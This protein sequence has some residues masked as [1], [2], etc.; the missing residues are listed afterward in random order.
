MRTPCIRRVWDWDGLRGNFNMGLD[1][2][3]ASV[4]PLPCFAWA[5]ACHRPRLQ[6]LWPVWAYELKDLGPWS[7]HDGT[8]QLELPLQDTRRSWD[9]TCV[10]H[11]SLEWDETD[12]SQA[13]VPRPQM[14]TQLAVWTCAKTK[15][16]TNHCHKGNS[17][18]GHR[19]HS[20]AQIHVFSPWAA[21]LLF[22]KGFLRNLTEV[23]FQSRH[24]AWI[25]NVNVF[26]N[27]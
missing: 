16:V 9:H 13:H 12:L 11:Y 7:I 22:Y 6:R 26:L 5:C 10:S 14:S 19:W 17:C 23:N 18:H 27:A 21:I 8:I 2:L 3:R 25:N 15:P 4:H 24:T 1:A 20:P